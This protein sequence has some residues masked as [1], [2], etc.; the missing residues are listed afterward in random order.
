[1]ARIKMS[2]HA[3]MP[4][5]PPANYS[6]KGTGNNSEVASDNSKKH[7]DVNPSEQGETANIRQNT[8]NKGFFKGRRM[9]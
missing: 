7:L 2:K 3:H 8:T 5:V 1:M 6:H 9:K 4:P